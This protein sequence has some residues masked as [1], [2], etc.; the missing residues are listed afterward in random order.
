M[1]RYR[2]TNRKLREPTL[3]FGS[4]QKIQ[5]IPKKRVCIRKQDY[6]M[7]HVDLSLSYSLGNSTYSTYVLAGVRCHSS[8]SQENWFY[9]AVRLVSNF[10]PL[11]SVL[12]VLV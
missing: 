10:T 8:T 2:K 1:F 7:S 11:L 4:V 3:K 12:F 5:T 6:N 9:G